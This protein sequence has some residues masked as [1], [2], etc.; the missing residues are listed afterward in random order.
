MGLKEKRFTKT[1]QEEKYPALKE[2]INNAAGFDVTIDVEWDTMFEDKFLHLYDDSYP[3]I[4]FQPLINAFAAIAA[5]DMGKEALAESLK[6][7]VI[8]NK[9]DHH[10][11]S[12]AYTFEEG[13][14]QVNHSPILNADQVQNRT[15][16]LVDLLENNL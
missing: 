10:N 9:D 13:V 5:D 4:Y 8:T 12:R 1:F 11:P 16:V 15:D 3:K 2:Q 6:K 14:L 7:V